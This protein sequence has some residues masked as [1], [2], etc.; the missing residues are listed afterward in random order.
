[1][2]GKYKISNFLNSWISRGLE[3]SSKPIATNKNRK[4]VSVDFSVIRVSRINEVE[5]E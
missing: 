5:F 1:M 3:V 4:P 2:K